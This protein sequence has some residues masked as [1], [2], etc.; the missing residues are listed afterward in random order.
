MIIIIWPFLTINLLQYYYTIPIHKTC[1]LTSYSDTLSNYQM[2]LYHCRKFKIV[3]TVMLACV[4]QVALSVQW[5]G[6]NG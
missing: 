2:V 1:Q 5:N 3:D 6:E 4:G